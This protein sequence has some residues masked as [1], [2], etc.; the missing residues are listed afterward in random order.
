MILS[1]FSSWDYN[2]T[3]RWVI[4]IGLVCLVLIIANTLRRKIPFLR[5]MLLPTAVIAGFL[6]LGLKYLILWLNISIDG[7]SIVSN[8]F[9]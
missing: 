1:T 3:W 9:F 8:E 5:N 2:N 6:G 4:Q 7:I